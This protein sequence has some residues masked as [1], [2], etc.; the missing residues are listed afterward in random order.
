MS[1]TSFDTWTGEDIRDYLRN[2][3]ES[4]EVDLTPWEANFVGS[5]LDRTSYSTKQREVVRELF[6]KYG[7]F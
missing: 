5:N 6:L 4:S 3:D 7:D 2:L 1:G